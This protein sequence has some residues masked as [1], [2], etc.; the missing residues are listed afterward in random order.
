[1]IQRDLTEEAIKQATEDFAVI[2]ARPVVKK[3]EAPAQALTILRGLVTECEAHGVEYLSIAQLK[4]IID[5]YN[6]KEQ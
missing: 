5:Q 2:A 1:M 6:F 3:L 4:A